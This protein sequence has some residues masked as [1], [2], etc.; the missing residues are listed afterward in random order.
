MSELEYIVP[1]IIYNNHNKDNKLTYVILNSLKEKE[2]YILKKNL[3][4]L[5]NHYQNIVLA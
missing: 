1:I 2:E 3:N 4:S 5:K